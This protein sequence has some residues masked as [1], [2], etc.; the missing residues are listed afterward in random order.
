MTHDE[1][2][3]HANAERGPAIETRG[4]AKTYLDAHGRPVEAVRGIDFTCRFGEIHGLLGP[5]GA[6]K[7]TTL[8]MIATILGPS[9]GTARV[10][11]HDVT[12]EPLEV[13]RRIGFLSASTGLYPRLTGREVLH[14]FGELH[15][16]AG[17]RLE[18]RIEE[19]VDA[20]ELAAFADRHTE[21]LSSGQRQRISIA[22]AMLKAPPVLILDEATSS[23]DNETE[24]A[25]QRSLG[26]LSV[27][28]TM[29][30]IAHRLST[31]RHADHIHVLEQGRI[32]ESGTHEELVEGGGL[33]AGLWRVQTGETNS[34]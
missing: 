32:V 34:G 10:A 5:N 21:T 20:F 23:V 13:R 25:I 19:L 15:G 9:A 4:L 12:R 31:I 3:A 2:E 8:R 29:V 6:G 30:V 22:R 11:G 26:L 7:T 17:E 16:F 28:R 18:A 14:Y 27:D 24:A 33:Y 1:P